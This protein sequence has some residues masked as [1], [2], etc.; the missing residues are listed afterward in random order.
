MHVK[1][2]LAMRRLAK[3]SMA[4][5]ASLTNACPCP[6]PG[7]QCPYDI[8]WGGGAAE[9]TVRP[10]QLVQRHTVTRMYFSLPFRWENMCLQGCRGRTWSTHA[11]RS[12]Q[13]LLG[14]QGAQIDMQFFRP[15]PA[16]ATPV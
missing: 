10:R 9:L 3:L 15:L 4:G 5:Q 2:D 8:S 12:A 7:W 6:A 16:V 1:C 14:Q 13:V 11:A